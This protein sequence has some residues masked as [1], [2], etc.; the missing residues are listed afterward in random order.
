MASTFSLHRLSSIIVS[1]KHVCNYKSKVSFRYMLAFSKSQRDRT[2]EIPFR[3]FESKSTSQWF[4]YTVE[5]IRPVCSCNAMLQASL[6][7]YLNNFQALYRWVARLLYQCQLRVTYV[8]VFV[9]I[10]IH[11]YIDPSLHGSICSSLNMHVQQRQRQRQR[12]RVPSPPCLVLLCGL[13]SNHCILKVFPNL[14]LL[15]KFEGQT[16]DPLLCTPYLVD[17]I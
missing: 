7:I 5:L 13:K 4:D 1:A 16:R 3:P 6:G 17:R 11:I 14:K 8:L 10:F 15:S 2:V 12:G 9:L